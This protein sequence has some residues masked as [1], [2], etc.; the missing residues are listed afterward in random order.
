MRIHRT[1]VCAVAL[2]LLAAPQASAANATLTIHFANQGLPLE[3]PLQGRFYVYDPDNDESYVAWGHA[4]R[5]VSVPEGVYTVVIKYVNGSIERQEVLEQIELRGDVERDVDFNL[6]VARLTVSITSGGL[7][8]PPFA[9]SFNLHR[10]GQRGTSLVSRRPGETVTVPPGLYDVEIV[11]RGPEGL[12]SKWLD[13]Y[14]LEGQKHETVDIGA[15]PARL[16]VTLL[17]SGRPL[18]PEAGEWRAYRAGAREQPLAEGRTGETRTL[19]PGV[20][21]IGLFWRAGGAAGERWL[22]DVEVRGN[23]DQRVDIG[24]HDDHVTVHLR[25]G[26]RPLPDAWFGLYRPGERAEELY[27]AG[28]GE[29]IEIRP[30][31]YDIGCFLRRR[32]VQA[33]RWVENRTLEGAVE[34]EVDLQFEEASF[35]VR[36]ARRGSGD[37]VALA[38]SLL[39]VVDSS[40]DMAAELED[41]TR[42]EQLRDTLVPAIDSLEGTD[43]SVGLRVFGIAP[44]GQQDCS[45][46]TLL[47]PVSGLNRRALSRSLDML[48]PAGRSPIARSLELAPADL[49]ASG[50]RFVVL[51]A[52]GPDSCDEDVC[53]A[54]ARAVREGGLSRIHIVALGGGREAR[55][56]LDCAGEYHEVRSKLELEALLRELLREVRRG[57]EGSV[58]LFSPGF[59]RLVVSG[60]LLERLVVTAGTYDVLIRTGDETFTWP[61]VEIRGAVEAAA[62]PRPPRHR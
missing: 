25:K 14:A 27:S 6:G 20:Y 11:Y 4:A 49:P 15:P 40:A 33:E 56:R 51:L 36:P 21:D 58:A 59:A 60:S 19:D 32:G 17:D 2:L 1:L 37:D 41:R 24:S 7:P 38:S 61:G 12:E 34:L 48:R 57:G 26:S 22:A 46:S 43:T 9:A 30:G 42:L 53:A 55:R 47:V 5:P 23:V 45:D 44:K 54:A 3:D 50:A 18:D 8:V 31:A 28:S 35:R 13:G 39:L 62:G 29:S 52:G 10:A 16:G